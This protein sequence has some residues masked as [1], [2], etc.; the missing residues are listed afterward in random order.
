[1]KWKSRYI[2]YKKITRRVT[3]WSVYTLSILTLL[4]YLIFKSS[5]VQTYITNQIGH[6]LSEKTNT[7]ITVESVDFRPFTTFVLNG[8]LVLD[9]QDDTLLYSPDFYFEID[10]YDLDKK[11]IELNLL[12]LDNAFLNIRKYKGE[13]KNN[14]AMFLEKLVKKKKKKNE[15]SIYVEEL[16]LENISFMYWDQNHPL[17]KEG[18][19]FKHVVLEEVN[20]DIDNVVFH[21]GLLSINC[22]MLSF[23]ERSGFKLIGLQGNMMMD[24]QRMVFRDF[25]LETPKSDINGEIQ[26]HYDSFKSFKHFVQEVEMKGDFEETVLDGNDIAY[27]APKLIGINRTVEFKG[28]ISGTVSDLKAKDLHFSYRDDTKFHGDLSIKGLPDGKNAVINAEVHDLVTFENDLN[29]IPLP[30]FKSGRKF[31]SPKWMKNMGRMTFQGEFS[32]IASDFEAFGTFKMNSG[33]VR[34]DVFFKRDSLDYTTISG[35]VYSELFDLGHVLGKKSLGKI[36]VSGELDAY[37]KEKDFRLKFSGDIPRFD[38]KNYAYSNIR[39]DGEIRDRVF[40]GKLDIKDTN[41]VFDFDGDVDFSNRKLQKYDFIANLKKANL[42]AINWIKRDS[43][44]TVSAKINIGLTGNDIEDM[45]GILRVDDLVWKEGTKEYKLDSVQLRS[46]KE[47]NREMMILNSD[48][49]TGKIEGNY[50]LNEIYPTVINVFSKE[51]PSLVKAY[52]IK[53]THVGGNKFRLMFKMFDYEMIHELFTPQFNMAN[54]SRF[55]GRFDDDNQTYLVQ[56]ASDSIFLKKR[57]IKGLK[58]YSKNAGDELLLNAKCD[59]VQLFDTVGIQNISLSSKV[60]SNILDYGLKYRNEG[61]FANYGDISGEID[62]NDLNKLK[63]KFGKSEANY[64]DTIWS[65]DTNN[66]ITIAGKHIT[67]DNF[68]FY[69]NGQHLIVDGIASPASRDFLKVDMNDF[70]LGTFKYFW[71]RLK[72]D[73]EGDATGNMIFRGV[74]GNPVFTSELDVKRFI[75]N[76]QRFGKIDLHASFIP[77]EEMIDVELVVDNRSKRLFNKTLKLNG[78]YYPFDNGRLDMEASMSNLQLLFLEKYF[79]GV[80]S[81]FKSGK[82]SGDL[83]IT[84]NI[85]KPIVEGKVRINQFNMKVDYLNVHYAVEA[86]DVKFKKDTIIFDDF[87][88]THNKWLKSKARV[89][90]IVTHNGFKKFKYSMDSIYLKNFYCLNTSLDENA[91]YYGQAF[92]D[93]LVQLKGDGNTN[94]IGGNVSTTAYQDEINSGKSRLTMPLDQT[95]E[96]ELSEFVNF[97]NLTDTTSS[98]KI[99]AEEELDLSGLELDLNFKI[100]SEAEVKIVF[101]PA[102]G[103]EIKAYGHGAIGMQVNSDGKFR[104]YGDYEVEEGNYYFTLQRIIG[105]KF[106]VRPKSKMS[107]DGDPLNAT[108]DMRTYYTSRANL[109]DLVDSSQVGSNYSIL[110]EQFNKRIRVN[111]D[112]ILRGSLWKPEIDIGISLPNG[113]PEENNHLESYIIGED[114]INRQAFTLLLASQF[115]PPVGAE[116]SIIG[117][118]LNQGLQVVEGQL[119]NALSSIIPNVDLGVDYNSDDKLKDEVRLLA[120]F[121]YKKFSVRTDYDINRQVGDIEADFRITDN[122][123]VRA[124]HKTTNDSDLGI[125]STSVS[126]TF[127][128]GASYQKSF[129]SF[130][131]LFRKEKNI[132]P[133]TEEEKEEKNPE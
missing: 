93:G 123:K 16:G 9:H 46:V 8:L 57:N 114:E 35:K 42:N 72:I 27:F 22:D 103:D 108:I 11:L 120:G 13:E 2:R 69:A 77:E 88:L 33:E 100:N 74:F 126:T 5:T 130:K 21:E 12:E 18:I 110:E 101:D 83:K 104:M 20:A 122:L 45:N 59:F 85:K 119:N 6:T 62:L 7:V 98:R 56:L 125:G 75:L 28:S 70:Q 19:D 41:L 90:G 50:N 66:A 60:D 55:S 32:G 81:E 133:D 76:G 31:K 68:K 37:A 73:L 25:E 34:T 127:G 4:S 111:T 24:N 47:T 49:F 106:T 113:T 58:L 23:K 91:T 105:R 52:P 43:S 89:N 92:V 102:V 39:M 71:D 30:P 29:S 121:Q 53:D 38:F 26:M 14:F 116:E 64:R 65:I 117:D 132:E 44:A 82:T 51:V 115:I 63:V 96:L 36:S 129:D 78:G 15:W 54:N 17:K 124:Y 112:L 87:V 94:Y 48:L 1:M 61:E 131:K 84:G 67:I 109:I 10:D 40:S 118:G 79:A 95:E 97:V 128:L 107:W 3:R 80:F 86:Q 99:L